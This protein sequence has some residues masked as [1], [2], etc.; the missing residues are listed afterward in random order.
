M[1]LLYSSSI[2]L[3]SFLLFLIQPMISKSLLPFLGS[4]PSSWHISVM[5][6]QFL[7]LIG[8][9][10]AHLIKKINI[11]KHVCLHLSLILISLAFLPIGLKS[12]EFL[13]PVYSPYLWSILSILASISL[14]FLLM[15]SNSVL[16]QYWNVVTSKKDNNPYFLYSISNAGTLIALLCYPLFLERYFKSS[17]NY[18]IWSILYSLSVIIS[19]LILIKIK[20]YSS[21]YQDNIAKINSNIIEKPK[22]SDR[23]NWI[24][25]SLVLSSLMLALTNHIT[26]DI[27]GIPLFWI[28]PLFL[29]LLSFVISFSGKFKLSNSLLNLELIFIAFML[30]SLMELIQFSFYDAIIL[31][32]LGF[33]IICL[34]SNQRLFNIKPDKKFLTE[35]Y[36]LISLGGFLGGLI[37]SVII[38]NIFDDNYEFILLILASLSIRPLQRIIKDKKKST[39]R[40]LLLS[41]CIIGLILILYTIYKS[42]L[43]FIILLFSIAFIFSSYKYPQRAVMFIG[44][45]ILVFYF[46]NFNSKTIY[47]DRNFFG[48]KKINKLTNLTNEKKNITYNQLN[49]GSTI[50]GFQYQDAKKELEIT[51]YY[52]IISKIYNLYLKD[53]NKQRIGSI[54]L[55]V[56]TLACIGD[57]KT[58]IDFF[59]ID[60][61]VIHIASNE[62]YFTYLSKCKAKNNIVHGDGRIEIKKINNNYYDLIVVDAFNSDS[63]PAHLLTIEAFKIYISKLLKDGII[64]FHIS[65]R[66]FDLSKIIEANSKYLKINNLH[67]ADSSSRWVFVAKNKNV[68]NKIKKELK[69]IDVKL[70][71]QEYKKFIWSDDKYSIVDLLID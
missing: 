50:H 33:F 3:S 19:I 51:S 27:G 47:K 39:N 56:G 71:D 1:F 26:Q 41:I 4:N 58:T 2:F 28:L 64:A 54:G 16:V 62:K 38:P 68:L 57:K 7:L 67:V 9:L 20:K 29:Y 17:L 49:H 65:N 61:Q 5:I 40:D 14:P 48:I 24:F 36:L 10:Y 25:I 69:A 15:S 13:N 46:F 43:I 12:I 52:P 22:N 66:H 30:A 6:Y 8:Y 60:K 55:G 18:N 35:F 34:T 42:N 59:E 23:F 21:N 11:N 32:L 70:S 63:I 45:V 37:I 44:S 31:N 53:K